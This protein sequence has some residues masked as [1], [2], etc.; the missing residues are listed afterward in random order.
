[1]SDLI[2][3]IFAVDSVWSVIT[4]GL[5]WIVAVIILA[6][7]ADEGHKRKRIKNEVGLFFLFLSGSGVLVYLI[8][9]FA[10]TF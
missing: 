5:I 7:G 1:M 6:Y 4:R 10:P 2:K 8:F 3:G 9:G